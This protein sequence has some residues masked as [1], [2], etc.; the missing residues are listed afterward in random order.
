MTTNT[1]SGSF[2]VNHQKINSA[3]SLSLQEISIIDFDTERL[4]ILRFSPMWKNFAKIFIFKYQTAIFALP[5][6]YVETAA[7]Q[8]GWNN[9]RSFE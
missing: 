8:T 6:N 9:C 5:K 4:I 3:A 7:D 2:L 1:Y